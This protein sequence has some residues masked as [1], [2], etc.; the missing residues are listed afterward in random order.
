MTITEARLDLAKRNKK[1]LHIILASIF[2]W[3]GVLIIWLLPIQDILTRNLFTFISTAPLL[4][5]SY[6]ISKAIKAEFS[7]KDNPLNNLS[8][9]FAMNQM[10]YIL[11]AMWIYSAMPDKMVMVLAMIFGAHL[12]PYSWIYHS[13]AYMVMS[14]IIPVV[15]LAVGHNLT[16]EK[17]YIIPLIMICIET[18]FSIWL[19]IEN[20]LLVKKELSI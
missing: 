16:E 18:V 8:V 5:L 19:F 12:L 17:V 10:L 6:L 4:P 20:K 3:T 15:A 7:A 1:G 2:V 11:I 13:K 9:L 14:I